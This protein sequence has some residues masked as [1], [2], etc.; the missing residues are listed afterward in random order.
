MPVDAMQN[1]LTMIRRSSSQVPKS[2]LSNFACFLDA[3]AIQTYRL[4]RD[5]TKLAHKVL[6]KQYWSEAPGLF[7]IDV[8]P[9]VLDEQVTVIAMLL[10]GPIDLYREAEK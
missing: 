4:S 7:Y 2:R 10:D 8:P 5:G 1:P 3:G 9:E 6:G